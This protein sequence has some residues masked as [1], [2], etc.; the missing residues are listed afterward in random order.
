MVFLSARPHVYSDIAEKH[1]YDSLN[2]LQRTRGLYTAPSLLCG[3]M[4]TGAQYMF[5][6]T[7]EPLAKKKVESFKE[8]AALY[9]E[10]EFVFIG[11]N[12]QGD[13]RAAELIHEDSLYAG[14][15]KRAY[16]HKV[17]PLSETHCEKEETKS[18]NCP[19]IF[20]FTTYVEA[21][22][23]AFKHELI[24][25]SG[26]RQIALEA[27]KDFERIDWDLFGNKRTY[28]N[29][30]SPRMESFASNQNISSGVSSK[31]GAPKTFGVSLKESFRKRYMR[32]KELNEALVE[33]NV[34]L[35][36]HGLKP[37]A[38]LK[39]E[40]LY[41]VGTQVI[42]P[43]GPG[44]VEWF[45]PHDGTYE[46]LLQLGIGDSEDAILSANKAKKANMAFLRSDSLLPFRQATSSWIP[47]LTPHSQ[48]SFVSMS[49]ANNV[50]RDQLKKHKKSGSQ[51]PAK[52]LLG[53]SEG[54]S[55]QRGEEDITVYKWVV[56]TPFGLGI[57]LPD[58]VEAPPP[59]LPE[60]TGSKK[61]SDTRSTHAVMV[62]VR[63]GWGAVL[64]ILRKDIVKMKL[65]TTHQ[66]LPSLNTT[67]E[68]KVKETP[69]VSKLVVSQEES[70]GHEL[71]LKMR[72]L[73]SPS[74]TGRKRSTSV[75]GGD[76]HS[77]HS[78]SA[79]NESTQKSGFGLNFIPLYKRF[80]GSD[81]RRF[82]KES[83]QNDFNSHENKNSE[84]DS[85]FPSTD[86]T[87]LIVEANNEQFESSS[88]LDSDGI[89][90]RQNESFN[91]LSSDTRND[92]AQGSSNDDDC[93]GLNIDNEA[94]EDGGGT[95]FMQVPS[96]T[97][98]RSSTFS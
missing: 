32:L 81:S 62:K 57:L 37:V 33:A 36:Q 60:A 54:G 24:R 19:Y 30:Q 55:I 3:S 10:F 53:K 46:V 35:V 26:L 64:S 15:L 80:F 90:V 82:E 13:V 56:W 29:M 34:L 5:N 91:D 43:F 12:G 69:H 4:K 96:L 44:V 50:L 73:L 70:D 45:R 86:V 93:V 98:N 95:V 85:P 71:P 48:A 61:A 18:V 88:S 83:L 39:F 28:A 25:I 58:K 6:N 75:D 8:Y 17:K 23:D 42:T 11:D 38:L 14:N 1:V 31:R 87:E 47:S 79:M 92:A 66:K 27:V 67:D 89:L 78:D 97:R 52:S 21:A 63:T 2:N 9:A 84:G 74:Q 7:M 20:Y 59:P 49:S 65:I 77:I 76:M 68:V 40:C 72:A 41:K 94:G 51:Q 16:M 22:V